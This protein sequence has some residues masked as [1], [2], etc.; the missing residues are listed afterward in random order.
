MN[1][2]KYLKKE[3]LPILLILFFLLAGLYVRQSLP[4]VVPTH[5]NVNN[6]PDGW[7]SRNFAVFFFP[8]LIFG[9]YLLLSI[10]PKI[11]PLKENVKSFSKIYH[12]FKIVLILFFGYIYLLSLYAALNHTLNIGRLMMIGLAWLFYYLAL[13]FP[14]IKRNYFFGIRLPWTLASDENWNKTHKFG[15]RVF[16]ILAFLTLINSFFSGPLSAIFFTSEMII[17]V[18]IISIYSYRIFQQEKN[19]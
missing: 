16:I 11:D 7:S 17:G 6:V 2:V 12:K 15:K 9:I 4:A 18:L 3:I 10:F 14:Q 1:K 13:I 19:N 8:G 5:W